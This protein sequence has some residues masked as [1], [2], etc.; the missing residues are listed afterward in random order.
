MLRYTDRSEQQ[1]VG[2][3]GEIDDGTEWVADQHHTA[4]CIDYS[5]ADSEQQ[6]VG[7]SGYG[8]RADTTYITKEN[9]YR[10]PTKNGDDELPD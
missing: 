9:G 10:G 7:S 2:S 3:C 1:R 5:R 4:S 8:S 6:R